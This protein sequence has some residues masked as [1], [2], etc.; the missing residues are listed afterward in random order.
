MRFLLGSSLVLFFSLLCLANRGLAEIRPAIYEGMTYYDVITRWGKPVEKIEYEV[1]RE[2][3]WRYASNT[4]NF[5][6]GKVTTFAALKDPW[7]IEIATSPITA[8][9]SEADV[10]DKQLLEIFEEI[11]EDFPEKEAED[12]FAPGK[13]IENKSKKNPR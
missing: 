5:R 8:N 7:D 13:I 12:P 2:A 10:N 11:A 3:S 9:N 1:K 4:V 6:E